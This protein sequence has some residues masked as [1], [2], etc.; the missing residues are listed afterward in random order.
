MNNRCVTCWKR[1]GGVTLVEVLGGLV[2]IGVVLTGL[3]KARA[4]LKRQ[5]YRA[6]RKAIAIEIADHL[7]NTWWANLEEFPIGQHGQ[8]T[9]DQI[10]PTDPWPWE[11]HKAG[12]MSWRTTQRL[13]D[14]AERLGAR[15]VRLEI[16]DDRPMETGKVLVSVELLL[17]EEDE[18]TDA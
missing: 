16:I 7:L 9:L 13:D 15:I 14:V 12:E 4:D 8:V 2:L 5:S 17:P 11:A 10:A 3:L 18:P 1:R 6:Q